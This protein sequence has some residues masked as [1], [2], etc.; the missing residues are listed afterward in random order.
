MPSLPDTE[1][2]VLVAITIVVLYLGF[3]AIGRRLKRKEG[4]PFGIAYQLFC[5][6][7]ALYVPITYLH[8]DF[9]FRREL[10]AGLVFSGTFVLI[11]LLQ[12]YLWQFYFQERRKIEIPTFLS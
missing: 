12:R 9:L 5:V 11:A 7:L 1:S 4:V 8:P 3:V 2:T 6:C 10:G